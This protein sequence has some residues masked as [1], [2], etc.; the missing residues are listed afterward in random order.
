MPSLHAEVSA[1]LV[2][3][4]NG[5]HEGKGMCLVDVTPEVQMVSQP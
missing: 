3:L 5:M 1:A 2:A 4:Y